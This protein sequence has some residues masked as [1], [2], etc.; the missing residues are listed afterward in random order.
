MLTIE[1]ARSALERHFAERPPAIAGTLHISGWYEDA[2][3]YLPVWGAREFLVDG[4]DEFQRWDNLAIFIDKASG[5]V[6]EEPFLPNRLKV[7]AMTPVEGAEP[8]LD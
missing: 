4:H 8:P 6:R 2:D 1:E 5:A 7:R 3:N